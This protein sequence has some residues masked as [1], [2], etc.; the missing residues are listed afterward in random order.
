M[1][2]KK[3]STKAQ[4]RQRVKHVYDLLVKAYSRAE[5]IEVICR[6]YDV[7]DKQVDIYIRK[8]TELLYEH[9][10]MDMRKERVL[11]MA[12]LDDIYQGAHLDKDR[13]TALQAQDQRNKITGMYAPIRTENKN[14]VVVETGMD[15]DD[16]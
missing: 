12:R 5:I 13:K 14:T 11:A 1:P 7:G 3:G 9:S 16:L 6:M 8:A 15:T 2:R 10:E 4:T